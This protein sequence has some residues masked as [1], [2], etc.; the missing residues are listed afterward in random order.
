MSAVNNLLVFCSTW[1]WGP[2]W[3]MTAWVTYNSDQ[4]LVALYMKRPNDS[5]TTYG[6][7]SGRALAASRWTVYH[8]S[9]FLFLYSSGVAV[10]F[11]YPPYT[12]D[13]WVYAGAT[14]IVGLMWIDALDTRYYLRHGLPIPA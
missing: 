5:D 1:V 13:V 4:R 14:M 6:T 12:L 8:Q 9:F 7:N 2:V 3:V 10:M 11:M